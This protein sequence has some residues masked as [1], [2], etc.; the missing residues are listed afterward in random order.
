MTFYIFAGSTPE[1]MLIAQTVEEA[2]AIAHEQTILGNAPTF[3]DDDG[4]LTH[5]ELQAL[6]VAATKPSDA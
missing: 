3:R 1:V 6:Y 5:F 4:P 2:L